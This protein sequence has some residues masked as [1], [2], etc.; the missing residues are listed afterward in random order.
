MLQPLQQFK[1]ESMLKKALEGHGGFT[2]ISLD[3]DQ[4]FT[5][6]LTENTASEK[7]KRQLKLEQLLLIF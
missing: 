3:N 6:K 5:K 1:T 2:E 4:I 7:G